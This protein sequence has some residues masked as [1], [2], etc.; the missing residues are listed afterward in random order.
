M[1]DKYPL[2][3]PVLVEWWNI[4]CNWFTIIFSERNRAKEAKEILDK[5]E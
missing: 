4:I 5:V 3:I 2:Q 1:C